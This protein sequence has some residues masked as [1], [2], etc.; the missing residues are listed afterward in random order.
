MEAQ[1]MAEPAFGGTPPPQFQIHVDGGGPLY[2]DQHNEEADR[3]LGN[4]LNISQDGLGVSGDQLPAK[5]EP[6]GCVESLK[7]R[8]HATTISPSIP[9]FSIALSVVPVILTAIAIV[10]AVSSVYSKA[11]DEFAEHSASALSTT[12][13]TVVVGN[14]QA[15]LDAIDGLQYTFRAT[16][17]QLPTAEAADKAVAYAQLQDLAASQNISQ[18]VLAPTLS[19]LDGKFEQTTSLIQDSLLKAM[20]EKGDECPT[21]MVAFKDKAFM[22]SDCPSADRDTYSFVRMMPNT[23][24]PSG[25]LLT[26]TIEVDRDTARN[27]SNKSYGSSV[28]SPGSWYYSTRIP[29]AKSWAL[30]IMQQPERPVILLTGSLF[31]HAATFLGVAGYYFSVDQL[32][33]MLLNTPRFGGTE[34]FLVS[35]TA[36]VV[37]SSLPNKST[38]YAEDYVALTPSVPLSEQDIVVNMCSYSADTRKKYCQHS[39]DSFGDRS[40][41]DVRD[42]LSDDLIF[43]RTAD[44][45]GTLQRTN[46]LD[47][48]AS[49][50]AKITNFENQPTFVSW[51]PLAFPGA[52]TVDW[53]LIVIL[54]AARVKEVRLESMRW[55]VLIAV[56]IIVAVSIVVVFFTWRVLRPLKDIVKLMTFSAYLHDAHPEEA[57]EGGSDRKMPK[58]TEKMKLQLADRT[59]SRWVEV[60]AI[61][62]AY[63][64]M[65]EELQAL[66]AYIPEHLR[67]E[68]M[69]MHRAGKVDVNRKGNLT[70]ADLLFSVVEKAEYHRRAGTDSSALSPDAHTCAL[71]TIDPKNSNT[72]YIPMSDMGRLD[73]DMAISYTHDSFEDASVAAAKAAIPANNY[74]QPIFFA[75]NVLVDRDITV[76]HINIVHFHYYA[77]CHPGVTVSR[78]YQ[79]YISFIH[80]EARR[81]GGILESFSGDKVW[82]SFNASSKCVNG[83]I[84]AAY[85]AHFVTST[86]NNGVIHKARVAAQISTMNERC[87][88]GIYFQIAP[89]G[90]TCGVATGRAFVGPLGNPA[91]KRHTII[92][93]AMAEA[94]A[95]ERQA[96]RYPGCNLFV[97]GDMIPAIEGYCQYLLMDTTLLP[98]SEGKRRRIACLKGPMIDPKCDIEVVKR[99]LPLDASPVNQY[100][101][102]NEA[103]NAFLEG[104]YEVCRKLIMSA[105]SELRDVPNDAPVSLRER[106]TA[107]DIMAD[108]LTSFLD[109]GVDGRVYRSPMGDCH[110]PFVHALTLF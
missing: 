11:I 57:S 45:A 19:L 50:Q 83:P 43:A 17:H 34:I 22:K 62:K 29:L 71:S 97:G 49:R 100:K 4:S 32:S 63:W 30:T 36:R 77:R 91:I 67:D 16:N 2:A 109:S 68:V 46:F 66:K 64:A 73:D 26:E 14:L 28:Y 35:G 78:D 10:L 105:T 80:K 3:D 99:W 101:T 76:V 108:L 38:Y 12:T 87:D 72:D 47:G 33:S 54:P 110:G 53:S 42:K 69:A 52:T 102:I 85:F 1:R 9:C 106:K 93:N 107:I 51:L 44:E 74:E 39:I 27:V 98:G 65:S 25:P 40:L 48:S 79:D 24:K 96:L 55:S 81:H 82:V 6:L 31:N 8:Y 59:L 89:N 104:Q 5:E 86:V 18:S 75:D 21:I 13:A 94:A 60:R 37:G 92:S 61:Q 103:M 58:L 56:L 95:L 20:R 70:E 84:A 41:I 15:S 7:A 88:E 90:V 23:S